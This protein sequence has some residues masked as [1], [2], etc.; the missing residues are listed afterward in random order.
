MKLGTPVLRTLQELLG[1]SDVSTTVVYTH[2][3]KVA[4]EGMVSPPDALGFG[5]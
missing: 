5:A 1:Y 2:M 3:L 4:V